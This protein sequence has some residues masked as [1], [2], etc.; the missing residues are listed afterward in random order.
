MTTL[1]DLLPILAS[2]SQT[3]D[4]RRSLAELAAAAQQSP[5]HFQRAF[6][7]LVG[8]SP[9]QFGRRLQLE[10]AAALLVSTDAR[11][12]DIAIRSGFESHEGFCRAFRQHF[13]VSPRAF[14]NQ[15]ELGPEAAA[16]QAAQ[17]LEVGP[18]LRLFRQ[19]LQPTPKRLRMNYDITTQP[20]DE[21]TLLYQEFRTEHAK[22]AEGL[23][24]A[25]PA[26]FQYATQHG[27][28]MVGPPMA[29]YIAWGPGM[30]TVRAGLPV[31]QGTEVPT[32][33]LAVAV[34]PAGRAAI[35]IHRGSYDGLGDAHA[36]VEAYLHEE[37]LESAGAHR[38]IYLTDPGEVPDPKDWQ[39]QIVWPVR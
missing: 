32:G 35:T 16:D 17:W 19:P 22:L 10:C 38:E 8:E 26:A 27:I 7:R 4:Q 39:T 30:A 25:M 24:Q 20:T 31:S 5:S 1:E 23:G 34:F 33:D 14:R 3:R 2:L 29:V 11:I 36:A 9:K 12:L 37:G 6:G 13:S 21:L 18:C 15:W 28:E